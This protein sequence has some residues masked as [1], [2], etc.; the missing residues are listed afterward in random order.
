MVVLAKVL[1]QVHF[2]FDLWTSRNMLSL[3]GI[4]VQE[5]NDD[6]KYN[7]FLFGL[8]EQ[9][10]AHSGVNIADSVQKIIDEFGLKDKVGYF[11]LD[12]AYNNDNC[13]EVLG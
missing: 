5:V 8:P 6:G 9:E 11:V 1:G 2:S 10:G 7:N 13:M 3:V 12:N 4:V